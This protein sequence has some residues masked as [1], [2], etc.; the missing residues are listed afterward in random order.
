MQ[1]WLISAVSGPQSEPNEVRPWCNFIKC[2]LIG[3]G[4]LAP[5]YGLIIPKPEVEQQTTK[6]GQCLPEVSHLVRKPRHLQKSNY[7]MQASECGV[8]GN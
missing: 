7:R 3:T 8:D 4:V 1:W 2:K 6:Q 5:K